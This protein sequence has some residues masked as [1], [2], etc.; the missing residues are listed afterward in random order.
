MELA[1][2]GL[3]GSSS[4]GAARRF[5]G[6]V[7]VSRRRGME[8]RG[9]HIWLRHVAVCAAMV[10]VM[11]RALIP[12]GFMLAAPGE[13]QAG[14]IP[15]VLCTDRGSITALL[16]EDGSIIEPGAA[17]DD[18]PAQHDPAGDNHDSCLFAHAQA[19]VSPPLALSSAVAAEPAREADV[20]QLPADL[21]PGRGLAAPPPPATAPPALI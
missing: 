7:K 10:A 17:D 15:I 4:P 8:T 11:L 13:A 14:G 16:A 21:V 1:E 5:T 12:A 2:P 19:G 6:G 3:C 18:A 9:A 20:S